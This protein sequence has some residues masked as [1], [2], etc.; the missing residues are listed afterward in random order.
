[1][2]VTVTPAKAP[3]I[4]AEWV[5]PGTHVSAMGADH[6]GKQ[7][8]PVALLRHA[9]LWV[10]HPAQAVRIGETQHLAAA[11]LTS[12]EKL[13]GRSLGHL[14][15]PGFEYVRDPAAVTVFDSSG[16]AV[17]DLAAAHAALESVRGR[18]RPAGS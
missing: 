16:V 17:Q 1:V 3:L 8:L 9:D 13:K 2:L 15:R 5:R 7:E 12:A 10:D 18:E 6:R 14:L 4:E 11:G